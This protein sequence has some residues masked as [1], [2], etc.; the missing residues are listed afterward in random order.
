MY[1]IE[2]LVNIRALPHW[3]QVA[4]ADDLHDAYVDLAIWR[5]ANPDFVFRVVMAVDEAEED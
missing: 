2:Q 5:R 3:V 4:E 1:M